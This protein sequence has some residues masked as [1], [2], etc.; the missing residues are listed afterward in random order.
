VR[1]VTASVLPIFFP[2]PDTLLSL[3]LDLVALFCFRASV[4]HKTPQPSAPWNPRIPSPLTTLPRRRPVTALAFKVSTVIDP[5]I[6]WA[7]A[8][9]VSASAHPPPSRSILPCPSRTRPFSRTS[10][11][12]GVWGLHSGV[13]WAMAH[14]TAENWVSIVP[15]KMLMAS[16]TTG[17]QVAGQESGECIG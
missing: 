9:L 14:C 13:P 3:A 15:I 2:F 6:S 4:T 8:R 7:A 1:L 5:R 10:N 17:I 11:G 12:D 16:Q